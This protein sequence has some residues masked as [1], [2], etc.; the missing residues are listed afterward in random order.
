MSEGI[1]NHIKD[2]YVGTE[3]ES[4]KDNRSELNN[5]SE[6]ICQHAEQH[7]EILDGLHD[8]YIKKNISYGNSAT[9]TFNEFG[10]TAYAVRL[11]DK[12]S[13]FKSIIKNPDVEMMLHDERTED[14]LLD[15][16]NYCIM[17][18]MDLR[19]EREKYGFQIS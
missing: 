13:R 11:S 12:M 17:A 19:E 5:R 9:Q 2:A 8:T 14:T 4:I 7:Q 16:A 15:M 3:N 18:V 6:L 1:T 10:L